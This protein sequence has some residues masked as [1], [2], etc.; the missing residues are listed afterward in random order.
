MFQLFACLC[1]LHVYTYTY[2]LRTSTARIASLTKQAQ[3]TIHQDQVDALS[4]QVSDEV[5][6]SSRVAVHGKQ[7]LDQ[8]QTAEQTL[9]RSHP[10]SARIQLYATQR[11]IWG[12]AFVKALTEY[13]RAKQS[14]RE[15]ETETL[16]RRSLLIFG[17][18]KSEA[19]IRHSVERNPTRFVEQAIVDEA[20]EDARLALS[21]AQNRARDV[22][23]L[24]QSIQEVE[25]MVQDLSAIVQTQSD[26]IVCIGENVDRAVACVDTGNKALRDGIELQTRTR[27]CMCLGVCIAI[28][29]ILA[30][31]TGL[32]ARFSV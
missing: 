8:F 28:L 23:R 30:I 24:V 2:A 6:E 5:A 12:R 13:Q 20:N 18:A 11:V 21:S 15:N 17:N 31:V 14:A 16:V 4:K 26:A 3:Q 32:V 9:R 19:E 29:V 22:E 10:T 1:A 25:V 27:K 7:I